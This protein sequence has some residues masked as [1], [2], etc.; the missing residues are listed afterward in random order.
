[1]TVAPGDFVKVTYHGRNVPVRDKT[2]QILDVNRDEDEPFVLMWDS[3]RYE[4]GVGDSAFVPF[5]AMALAAGDPRSGE[6]MRSYRDESGNTGFI[7][8]RATEVRR[9]RTRYDNQLGDESVIDFAPD[10][11]VTDLEDNVIRT[12]LDDPQGDSV[13][14]VVTTVVDRDALLAQVQRQQR[15]IEML[16]ESQ[17]IDLATIGQNVDDRDPDTDDGDGNSGDEFATAPG[18]GTATIPTDT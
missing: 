6:A 3:R 7:L 1:M 4:I 17:G 15:M 11:S 10:F 18:D 12:V 14:A 2:G 13:L 5:D 8:D 16:A 9:L